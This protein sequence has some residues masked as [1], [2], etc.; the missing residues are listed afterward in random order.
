MSAPVAFR[1]HA[2]PPCDDRVL[3]WGHGARTV[4]IR[5]LEGRVRVPFSGAA[6]HPEV[7]VARRKGGSGLIRDRHGRWFLAATIDIPRKWLPQTASSEWTW[8][9]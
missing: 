4:S 2:A 5:T 7:L 6:E 9:G 3:S 8:E 1:L